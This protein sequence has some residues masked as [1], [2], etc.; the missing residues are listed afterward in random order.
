MKSNSFGDLNVVIL[1]DEVGGKSHRP[2]KRVCI[3][4]AKIFLLFARAVLLSRSKKGN[5]H[6]VMSS[7]VNY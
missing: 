6:E 5:S 3:A 2:L 7:R 1:S 4:G